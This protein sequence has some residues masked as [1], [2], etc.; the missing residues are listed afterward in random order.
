MPLNINFLARAVADTIWLWQR[1]PRLQI[2]N[3][4]KP[5]TLDWFIRFRSEWILPRALVSRKALQNVDAQVVMLFN[6]AIE[7][8]LF[9]VNDPQNVMVVSNQIADAK[10]SSRLNNFSHSNQSSM[11][12]KIAFYT[13]P[14]YFVPMDGSAIAGIKAMRQHGDCVEGGLSTYVEYMG[15]FEC[16]FALNSDEIEQECQSAWAIALMSR[17]GLPTAYAERVAFV[18]KTFDSYLMLE[19]G[20]SKTADPIPPPNN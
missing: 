15:L 9:A 16:L 2:A 11:V 19:G 12:S 17:I 14:N 20:R 13:N 18:R 1:T 5:I 8:G 4:Y 6:D 3:P 7:Q 10:L